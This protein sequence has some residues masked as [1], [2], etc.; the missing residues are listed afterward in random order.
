MVIGLLYCMIVLLTLMMVC[1]RSRKPLSESRMPISINMD[2]ESS[3][4]RLQS[5]IRSGSFDGA[6]RTHFSTVSFEEAP[7]KDE[8][9]GKVDMPHLDIFAEQLSD[10]QPDEQP[11]S[12]REQ[13]TQAFSPDKAKE[14]QNEAETARQYRKG[15]SA[16]FDAARKETREQYRKSMYVPTEQPTQMEC[17]N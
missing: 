1:V 14:H 3:L 6:R 5:R 15:E 13:Q 9:S 10:T 2:D 4:Q 7:Q 17:M 11:E 8:C 12:L 16:I